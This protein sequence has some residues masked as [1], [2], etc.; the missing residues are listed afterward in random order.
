MGVNL[1]P[2][3]DGDCRIQTSEFKNDNDSVRL[4]CIQEG[5]HRVLLFNLQLLNVGDK[6]LD[7]GDPADHPEIYVPSEI[8]PFQFKEKFYTWKLK[9]NS[10]KEVSSGYK[11]AF[12]LMDMGGGP[13]N[14]SN[15]GVSVGDHDSYNIG[16][17]CQFVVIDDL[18]EG[19]YVLEI[20][21][22]AF[23]VQEVKNGKKP[24]IEEDNYDD[25]TINV[26]L[27]IPNVA[28]GFVTPQ[29]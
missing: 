27:H 29:T 8:F 9:D 19:D 7:I 6:D 3:L 18:Q 20:T 5:T 12:C 17:P 14:C 4:G 23:S 11:V 16:L 13:H 21:A 28:S 24:I 25:N 1:V 15:Q 26:R 10:G 22:N 2:K